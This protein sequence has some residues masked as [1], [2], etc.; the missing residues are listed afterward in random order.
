MASARRGGTFTRIAP[1]TWVA[2]YGMN[3]AKAG[4]TRTW[5]GSDFVN[6]QMP[7]AAKYPD[8]SGRVDGARE[9]GGHE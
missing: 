4:E 9:R 1:N 3:L 2:I 8:A 6:G 7:G 5:M